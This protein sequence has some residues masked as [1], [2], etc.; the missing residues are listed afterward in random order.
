MSSASC[1][2]EIFYSILTRFLLTFSLNAD[3]TIF[4]AESANELQL[5]FN[6]VH[7]IQI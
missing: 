2:S 1:L 7:D 5:A 3:D 4:V 6:A